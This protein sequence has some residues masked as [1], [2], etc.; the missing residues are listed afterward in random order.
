MWD[1][2]SGNGS[3][4]MRRRW[5]IIYDD[6]ENMLL[7]CIQTIHFSALVHIKYFELSLKSSCQP[8]YEG[9]QSLALPFLF[10]LTSNLIR[11]MNLF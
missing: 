10:N 9:T 5:M 2:G 1:S 3:E 8:S 7:I 11:H 4:R 6:N